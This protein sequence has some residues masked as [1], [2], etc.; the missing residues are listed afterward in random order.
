MTKQ[1]P[2]DLQELLD[3]YKKL[4]VEIQGKGK[5]VAIHMEFMREL[6]YILEFYNIFFKPEAYKN[7]EE[8]GRNAFIGYV[9]ATLTE[10]IAHRTTSARF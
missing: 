1:K 10:P 2:K 8:Y 5:E 9:L 4:F 6:T 7:E 3:A